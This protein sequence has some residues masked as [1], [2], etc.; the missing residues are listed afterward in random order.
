MTHERRAHLACAIAWIMM[1]ALSPPATWAAQSSRNEIIQAI[2]KQIASGDAQL[3]QQAI[4]AIDAALASDKF[5]AL[6]GLNQAWLKRLI[7]IKRYDDAADLAQRAVL[8]WPNSDYTIL[9]LLTYRVRALLAVGKP[10]EALADARSA[11]NVAGMERTSQAMKLLWEC[12][13]AAYPQ[14]HAL[15]ER[16]KA[17]QWGA[18]LATGALADEVN[19]AGAQ[20]VMG[21]IAIDPAVYDKALADFREQKE[22]WLCRGNLMLMAGKAKEAREIFEKAYA[23]AMDSPA[24]VDS[25]ARCMKAEDGDIGRAN[26]YVSGLRAGAP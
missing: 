18:V 2:D 7:S 6:Q 23:G 14:D 8:T 11:F 17:E 25:V 16:F 26:K 22:E 24:A 10:K 9:P 1:A 5:M 20:S 13:L 21:S 19:A 15:L 4:T 12:L 3:V